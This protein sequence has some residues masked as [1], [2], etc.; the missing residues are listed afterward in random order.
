LYKSY[1]SH[2]NLLVGSVPSVSYTIT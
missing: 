2:P 1:S